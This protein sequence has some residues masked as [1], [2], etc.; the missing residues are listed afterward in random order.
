MDFK[1]ARAG[2]QTFVYSDAGEGPLVVLLHGFPD[3]PR[4]WTDTGAAL[5]AGGYRTVIP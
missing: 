5:N 3:T 1:T 4:G 2:E